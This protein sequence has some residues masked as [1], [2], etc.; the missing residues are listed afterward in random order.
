MQNQQRLIND[1]RF[2]SVEINNYDLIL[3]LD[4]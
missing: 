4:V 1:L 3:N 2:S